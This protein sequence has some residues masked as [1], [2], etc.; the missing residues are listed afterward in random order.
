MD[1]AQNTFYS[2]QPAG[3]F[4]Q[5]GFKRQSQPGPSDPILLQNETQGGEAF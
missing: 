4:L 1:L 3:R 5:T 2:Q